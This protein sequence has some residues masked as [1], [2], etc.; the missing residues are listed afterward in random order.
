M[1]KT[2]T[3]TEGF[4]RNLIIDLNSFVDNLE[5]ELYFQSELHG[6]EVPKEVQVNTAELIKQMRRDLRTLASTMNI[7]PSWMH[8]S[9]L[10]ARKLENEPVCGEDSDEVEDR[11]R[12]ASIRREQ[13]KEEA[14]VKA[15]LS[16]NNLRSF[17]KKTA[18]DLAEEFGTDDPS[19]VEDKLLS[20]VFGEPKYK[21][22]DID[23]ESE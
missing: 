6:V 1:K 9:E 10:D 11:D 18:E 19:E 8:T 3:F 16:E 13:A 21:D 2:T 4:Q 22:E 17:G 20:A 23:D 7:Y 5:L 12:V 15:R 14:K